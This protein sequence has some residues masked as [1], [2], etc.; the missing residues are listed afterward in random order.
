MSET[1]TSPKD[2]ARYEQ[3]DVSLQRLFAFAGGVVALVVVGVLGSAAVFHFFV[4]HQ[5]LGPPPTPFENVRELPP[6]P[7]LQ[8]NA[9]LD[10]QHYRAGQD[11]IL[12][13]YGWVDSQAG[14]VRIPID[15][16]MQI[17][18]HKG[19]PIRGSSPENGQMNVPGAAPPPP[20]RQTAPTPI[21]GEKVQ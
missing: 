19:Y 2:Q 6:A 1:E 13:S 12:H 11:Q 21:F 10:L 8:V 18:L 15:Q 20:N 4:T 9:P 14:I 5:S 17:L 7:R 16:A 3:A